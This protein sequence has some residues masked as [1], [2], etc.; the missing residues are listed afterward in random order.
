MGARTCVISRLNAAEASVAE[1]SSSRSTSTVVAHALLLK[2]LLDGIVL[3]DP[4]VD[5]VYLACYVW[6]NGHSVYSTLLLRT[7][8][9]G[10]SYY[11]SIVN[12]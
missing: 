9:A 10:L 8:S 4:I 1:A 6:S 3:R 11:A 5:H 2:L 7:A 12:R